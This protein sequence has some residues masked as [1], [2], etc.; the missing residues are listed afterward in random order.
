MVSI[1]CLAM[2]I[3]LR[4]QICGGVCHGSDL[5]TIGEIICKA[6]G[7][8]SQY[9]TQPVS[10]GPRFKPRSDCTFFSPCDISKSVVYEVDF[11]AV[12]NF[13]QVIKLTDE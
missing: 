13:L 7:E 1:R 3:Y 12:K 6:A 8:L 4:I 10:E 5:V 11:T 9:S 2:N